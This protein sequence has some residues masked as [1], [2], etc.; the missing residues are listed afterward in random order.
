MPFHLESLWGATF[1]AA[2]RVCDGLRQNEIVRVGKNSGPVL[3]RLLTEVHEILGRRRRPFVLANPLAWLS[4]LVSFCS[5]FAIKSRGRRKTEQMLKF[6]DP[7]VFP[8][9]R[10]DCS[11]ADC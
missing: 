5:I 8:E 1:Y 6:L 10:P 3:S 11:R 7:K 2:Y 4:L 9:G